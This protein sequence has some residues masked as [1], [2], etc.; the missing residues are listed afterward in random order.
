VIS[1]VVSRCITRGAE[2]LIVPQIQAAADR[3]LEETAL[4]HAQVGTVARIN[5]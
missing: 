1:C 3:V 4:K 2:H 5:C